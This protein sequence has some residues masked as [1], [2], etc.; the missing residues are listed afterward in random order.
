LRLSQEDV[1]QLTIKLIEMMGEYRE[2]L[3][4]AIR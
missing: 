3:E 4:A 2:D 1:A